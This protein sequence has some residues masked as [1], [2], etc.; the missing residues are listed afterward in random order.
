M[1][2]LLEGVGG[3]LTLDLDSLGGGGP[4]GFVGG[5]FVALEIVGYRLNCVGHF[6]LP[7]NLNN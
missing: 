1:F 7:I 5:R 2:G 6:T 3:G 4:F